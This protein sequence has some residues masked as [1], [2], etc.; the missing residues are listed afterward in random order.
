MVKLTQEFVE[1]A[2]ELAD[3]GQSKINERERELFGLS[4]PRVKALLNNLC[5]LKGTNYLELGVY[6]GSTLISALFG[7]PECKAVG[8]DNFRYDE[9][10]PKRWAP[11]NDIW[12][13]VKSQLEANLDR[14][15]NPNLSVNNANINIIQDDFQQIDW[16]TQPKFNLVFFDITP[17]N[18]DVYDA[19]FTKVVPSLSQ[20]SVVVFSN[21]SNQK[22]AK[23]LDSVLLKYSDK[24]EVQWSKHRISGGLSDFTQ[25]YSGILIVGLKKVVAKTPT[26]VVSKTN[27]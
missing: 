21:Y 4:S 15:D 7:N 27:A 24:V 1:A 26:K 6:R 13:N 23:E 20:D 14:Y 22:H 9:R 18:E 12:H 10:E 25:Y 16:S 2:L 8:V 11:E 3:K 19:F 17:T 5:C